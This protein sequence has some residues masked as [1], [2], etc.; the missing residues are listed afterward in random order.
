MDPVH[1]K[2][3]QWNYNFEQSPDEEGAMF[4]RASDDN[5]SVFT[6]ITFSGQFGEKVGGREEGGVGGSE[7]VR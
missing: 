6:A 4:E 3:L 7:G 2:W 1:Y 5:S